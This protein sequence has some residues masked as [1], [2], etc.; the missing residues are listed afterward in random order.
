MRHATSVDR[1]APGVRHEA[2][3]YSGAAEYVAG[4]VPFVLDGLAAGEDV[5]VVVGQERAEQMHAAL[6][7]QAASVQ[8]ADMAEVGHNPA[9]IIPAW[10]EFLDDRTARGRPV[11]GIGEPI[12]AAR[13]PAELI[14]CQRHE[15]L[16][17]VAFADSPRWRLLCPYDVETLRSD[18][19]AEAVRTHPYVITGG[20]RR[21]VGVDVDE[22]AVQ[23]LDVPLPEPTRV[24]D[25]AA[26]DRRGLRHV[27]TLVASTAERFGMDP[28]RTADLVV[29]VNE[30]TTNS[31][32]HAGGQGHLRL[33][34]DGRSLVCEV[35]DRGRLDEPL[36]G[37]RR[38]PAGSLGGRGL[39]LANQLCDLVQIRCYESGT[40]VRLHMGITTLP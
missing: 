1:A 19:L 3:F 30:V 33:W 40:V 29:A 21:A 35:C 2:L 16:L 13:T 32:T 4:T 22:M 9:Q 38:P 10:Q 34:R 6:G 26:F 31:V 11:R 23:Y 18:V 14:E 17:N 20:V 24:I 25:E 15:A 7:G 27:R 28:A 39:W 36:A 5:L 8:F 12:W 37:R